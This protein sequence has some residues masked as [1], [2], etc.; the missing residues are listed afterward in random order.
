MVG[1]SQ[2]STTVYIGLLIAASSVALLLSKQ[3]LKGIAIPR[4]FTS[5]MITTYCLSLLFAFV[6]PFGSRY[7]YFFIILPL[8]LFYFPSK[9]EF[10]NILLWSM[11]IVA[12]LLALFYYSNYSNNILYDIK[13]QYNGSYSVLYLL[14]FILC[15]KNRFVRFGLMA[16][17]I[18]IV[19]ISLKRGGFIAVILGLLTYF[20]T[21]Y[22]SIN[23]KR[24]KIGH[25]ILIVAAVWG[26]FSLTDYINQNII[27]NVLYD[28]IASIE[29]N[30][31]GGRLEVYKNYI[32][33][34]V[35]DSL[36]YWF[37]GHGWTGSLRSGLDVTCHN[38]FLEVFVDFGVIGFTMYL[39]FWVALVKL[40][41]K[42]IREKN[43]YAPAMAA[44]VAIFLVNSMVSHIFIYSWYMIEFAL[45]WGY[46]VSEF[47]FDHKTHKLLS[48][49]VHK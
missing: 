22:F 21:S 13:Q 3:S 47:Y 28:R 14:P 36:F 18:F 49:R 9:I 12:I 17:V 31:G 40:T 5:L 10:N 24:F 29:E 23:G 44:S 1:E 34:I 32:D 16:M 20:V 48:D 7:T 11:T 15:L 19:M 33:F 27:G 25:L 42:M 30:E 41:I 37:I 6:Y 4:R 38:D 35:S 26:L 45:F 39:S 2:I 46:I 43:L 8:L